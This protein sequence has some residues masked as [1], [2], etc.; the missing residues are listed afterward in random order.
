MTIANT[1]PDPDVKHILVQERE[2]FLPE[3]PRMLP[4]AYHPKAAQ[5]EFASNGWVR[6]MLGEC[7]A[8]EDS[9]LL[10]LRQRNGLYGPLTVPYADDRRA[11][12]IA[13]W[14]QYVTVIDSFVS[15]RS[16]LGGSTEK[17]RQIFL[18]IT[19]DF[20]GDSPGATAPAATSS[21]AAY[22]RAAQDLWRRISPALTADQVRRFR[23]SLSAFLDG[24]ATEIQ[25]KIENSVPDYE[26]CLLV[27]MNSFGCDFIEL[28]TEYA[29]E[30]DMTGTRPELEAVHLHCMRQMIIINDLLSW[31]KEHAQDDKMTVV[32]VLI[33]REG[34]TLQEA[35]DR[36]TELA[37]QHERA[38]I[39]ARDEILAGPLGERP[40]VRAYLRGLDFLMGGSQEFEYL[41]PR[42]F[43]DG[44]VWDTSTSGW[45]SLDAPVTRFRPTPADQ[46]NQ[47]ETVM[48][49]QRADPGAAAVCPVPHTQTAVGRELKTA[50]V[51]RR[52]ARQRQFRVAV[53][54][55]AVPV[56]GHALKMW[57][58][59]RDFVASLPDV[60]DL[61]EIRFGP[62]RAYLACDIEVAAQVLQESRTF[63]K[64]GPLF[65][66]ARVLVGNG[67]VSS[68]WEDHRYQRRMLQPA[69]HASRMANY[70]ALMSGEIDQVLSEWREGVPFDVSDVMHALTLRITGRTMFSSAVGG[71]AVSEVAYCMP[72]IMRGVYWRMVAPFGW[73]E[74]IPT[75]GNREYDRVRARMHSMISETIREQRDTGGAP[76]SLLSILLNSQDEQTGATLSEEELYDQ[77]MTLL[78]GGTE[79]TGNTMAWVFYMLSQ[80]PEAEAR[81][82]AEVDGVLDGRTPNF[83]D[84]PRLE[85][86]WK[87]L[88]ETL[89]M[90]PPAWLLTRTTT[91]ETELAGL[92]LPP[93]ETV[94]YSPYALGRN[95][96][97]FDDPDRFDPDRWSTERAKSIPRGA[98][99]AF[100]AGSRKC[101]GDV[102]GQA[103]TTLS[104]AWIAS[105]WRL[106][107]APGAR[108]H[109]RVPKASLGTGPLLMIPR[110]RVRGQQA[111]PSLMTMAGGSR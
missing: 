104:L 87:V 48:R 34:C 40:D 76:G 35:V 82:H 22:A 96:K 45:V 56:L 15:D 10:F 67:L 97:F 7:F 105:Q 51:P 88:T 110:R 68:D 89:R 25:A 26:T 28:M 50:P 108:P 55:G 99:L 102:F 38:Y 63:D 33:Q 9:L 62:R 14:Y 12:D 46:P 52:T 66:K 81:L 79:T 32:R 77:V 17:A 41:T 21:Q 6:G 53:A 42:Y 60:G 20:S 13:D 86:T 37:G 74:K 65:D 85:Y 30:V 75:P 91:T 103:E 54:P 43:G 107:L 4:V 23:E 100:G 47:P 58:R 64:G 3:L 44:A 61:V 109:T 69:F 78:I 39:S 106:D 95:H 16:A 19:A 18:G 11:R 8:D 57:R 83:D 31:R 73:Y 98:F 36:L 70:V 59:P 90:F 24:C 49:E 27:R 93:G 101:I 71:R 29:A 80:H 1:A 2:F 92:R 72:I 5:I 94:M 84:L 111:S